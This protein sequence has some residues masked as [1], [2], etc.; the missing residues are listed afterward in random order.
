MACVN[1]PPPSEQEYPVVIGWRAWFDD[2][3]VY[4]STEHEWAELPDDGLLGV[5]LF[6][7]TRA[8]DGQRTRQIISSYDTYFEATDRL[9][10][11]RFYGGNNDPVET[12][13]ARYLDTVCKRGRWASTP[14][15][16]RVV[17][18]LAEARWND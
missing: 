12:V 4:D 18:E 8:P 9:T 1:C 10:G 14:T 13:E 2:G 15:I 11:A 7:S 6:E 17:A 3:N 16:H 5:V